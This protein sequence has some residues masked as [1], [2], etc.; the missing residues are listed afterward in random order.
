MTATLEASVF[1]S[2]LT[3]AGAMP[4]RRGEGSRQTFASA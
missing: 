4:E 2:R 1:S 3:V